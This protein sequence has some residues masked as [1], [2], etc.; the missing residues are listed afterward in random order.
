VTNNV[1][2]AIKIEPKRAETP[3]LEYE[4][5]VYHVLAGG[6]FYYFNLSWYPTDS[7]L[8]RNRGI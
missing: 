5:R 7:I 4:S 8:W 1:E 6:R 2:L 3:Q